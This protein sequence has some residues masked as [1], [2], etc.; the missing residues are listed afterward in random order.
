MNEQHFGQIQ[1]DNCGGFFD[2]DCIRWGPDPF[3]EEIRGDDTPL[4]LCDDCYHES[5][6]EI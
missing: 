2:L 4:W 3:A 1:C 6:M 5:C